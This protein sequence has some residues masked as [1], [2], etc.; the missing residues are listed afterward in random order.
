MAV[1]STFDTIVIG[2]GL[3]GASAARRLALEGRVLVLE[4]F[5]A[6]HER[7]SSHGGS[8]IFRHAYVDEFHTSLALRADD[9]WCELEDETGERLLFRTGGVDLFKNGDPALDTMLESLNRAGSPGEVMSGEQ[10]A[11]RWPVFGAQQDT[12]VVYHPASAV[13]PATRAVAT[14]LR[15]ALARGAVLHEN[16][17]V[18]AF[19]ARVDGVTVKTTKGT[20]EAA[21]LVVAAGGWLRQVAGELD[22][23][24]V[25][26]QQ[27]V[28]YLRAADRPSDHVVGRLPV[29]I[30]R[31]LGGGGGIY[32]LPGFEL[33]HA[34]KVAS[35]G[36][37][38]LYQSPDD[39]DFEV[40][41]AL[42]SATVQAA[43]GLLPALDPTPMAPITCLYT[44]TPDEQFIVDCHPEH[45][46]V[47]ILGGGS[48]HAF[49]FGPLFGELTAQLL[50]TGHGHAEFGIKR[51][52]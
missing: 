35:H 2:A 29:F 42:A 14:L 15:S 11:E 47:V 25:V 50:A 12:Q 16:E 39:R 18:V 38:K 19:E 40:S 43:V 46:N 21:H 44:N 10:L 36:G 3:M 41:Q 23:P 48:G 13:V 28:L 5:S 8:R 52:R 34:V 17:P 31:R 6:L 1:D 26:E 27:Q 20:Y 37:G 45:R 49:K 32:G 7:G 22:L 51:F 30:E 33:P 24:L 4:Q 9:L